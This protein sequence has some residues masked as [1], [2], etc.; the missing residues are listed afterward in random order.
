MRVAPWHQ[1]NWDAR[2]AGNFIGGGSGAGLLLCAGLAGPVGSYR[3]SAVLALILTALGLICVLAEIGRPWRSINVLRHPQT[4]WMTREAIIAPFLFASGVAAALT[5]GGLNAL[6]AA[7]FAA[8]YLYSQARMLQAC[9]GIPAWRHKASIP[10]M[11]G[12]GI[13]EGASLAT[14]L[15][16]ASGIKPPALTW[17]LL[18]ALL[19]RRLFWKRYIDA[20]EKE[21]APDAALAVLRRLR[22]PFENYGQTLPELLLLIG[23]VFGAEQAWPIAIAALI[24][25]LSGWTLKFILVARAAYN[26]GFAL[27]VLP[28]RGQGE[29]LPGVKPGWSEAAP[30]DQTR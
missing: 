30:E 11:L 1:T 7:V 9:K 19:A 24:G 23:I 12:T 25:V 10:L 29:T 16:L 27:P 22:G 3:M 8:A 28:I 2:A 21:G 13:V 17:L 14:L 26:Q 4:S 18:V 5:G 15:S 20:L 6:V